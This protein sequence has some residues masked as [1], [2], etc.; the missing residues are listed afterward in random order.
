M[1]ADWVE[2]PRRVLN[3]P[4]EAKIPFNGAG[5]DPSGAALA[6]CLRRVGTILVTT[7]WI[8]LPSLRVHFHRSLGNS[9]ERSHA[10]IPAGASQHAVGKAPAPPRMLRQRIGIQ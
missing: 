4:F 10:V 9:L 6:L 3:F 5:F 2:M 1:G 8:R 7:V